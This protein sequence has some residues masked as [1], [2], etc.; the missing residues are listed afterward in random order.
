M[1]RSELIKEL[2]ALPSISVM[3]EAADAIEE[4]EAAVVSLRA[5]VREWICTDCMFVYPGPPQAGS[6]CVVCP[7]CSGPTMPRG[8]SVVV[9]LLEDRIASHGDY[10]ARL[11]RA[12]AF[13]DELPADPGLGVRRDAILGVSLAARELVLAWR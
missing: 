6:A 1:D 2:R 9:G 3:K 5:E 7:R 12:L 4:L 11:Q 13:L 8:S 10:V